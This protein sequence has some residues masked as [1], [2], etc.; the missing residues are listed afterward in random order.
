MGTQADIPLNKD[1]VPSTDDLAIWAPVFSLVP[2]G[3]GFVFAVT[4][5][6][7]G[8][9]A[10]PLTGG[11]VGQTGYTPDI[12]A[13]INI[14]GPQGDKGEDGQTGNNGWSP[15]FALAAL[16]SGG[17]GLQITDWTG[18]SGP[19]P[20]TG[21]YV[22]SSGLS[23][24][25]GSAI[26]FQGP[27]G[28]QGNTGAT[29]AAGANGT[30]GWSPV[31][32]LAPIGNNVYLQVTGWTGGTGTPPSTIGYIGTS[33]IVSSATLA[34]NIMGAQGPS[35]S[36]GATGAPGTG[37]KTVEMTDQGPSW[38][39]WLP[40]NVEGNI[41][42][43]RNSNPSCQIVLAP[44][45]AKGSF[46]I[47]CYPTYDTVTN[48]AGGNGSIFFNIDA[49]ERIGRYIINGTP[50]YKATMNS[51]FL[52]FNTRTPFILQGIM[53]DDVFIF[54]VHCELISF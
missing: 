23:N 2:N 18:G 45:T 30:N 14:K 44:G 11:Y 6:I 38:Q 20:T 4:N 49:G 50:G 35:G 43:L 10:K 34:L 28:P 16:P 41:F 53:Q 9:G 7:G 54:N 47:F 26:N 15:V 52:Y 37:W 31:I 40:S 17:F 24:N 46:F 25:V 3:G 42:N 22:T 51:K 19:K 13:A 8:S 27:Q 21:V 36:V 48:S 32:Q 12:N 29:G 39:F 1:Q 5:W 33:G